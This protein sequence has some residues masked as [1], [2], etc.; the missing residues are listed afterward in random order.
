MFEQILK[1]LKTKYH[2]LGLKEEYLKVIAKRL[3]KT[4]KEE[5]EINDAIAEVEDEMKY[6]QRQDDVF[7]SLQ[8]ELKKIKES[9]GNQEPASLKDDEEETEP[10]DEKMPE[11]AKTILESN[12]ALSEK[13]QGFEAEKVNQSNEQKLIAK[14]KELG[15]N[16]H[17]YQLQMQG[18]TFQSDEEIETFANSVKNA[19][20]GFIQLLNDTKLG[21]GTP[22]KKG[23]D[24][25]DNEVS[26]DVQS[27]IKTKFNQDEGN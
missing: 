1:E 26:Q 11:W 18:K 7:R 17:F 23:D 12:K 21:G 20:T 5:S 6:Q 9:K 14:F 15:V 16:E 22:P 27:F 2:N 19:E 10:K 8:T 3:A 4:V 25:K 13:I 24:G